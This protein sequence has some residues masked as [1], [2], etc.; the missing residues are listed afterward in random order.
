MYNLLGFLE[1]VFGLCH[2]NFSEVLLFSSKNMSMNVC[3]IEDI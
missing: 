2:L 3:C 1:E